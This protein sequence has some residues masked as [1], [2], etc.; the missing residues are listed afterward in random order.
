MRGY[1]RHSELKLR[2]Q[3]GNRCEKPRHITLLC[4]FIWTPFPK[5]PTI[6]QAKRNPDFFLF[7]V[8]SVRKIL[9]DHEILFETCFFLISTMA[10]AVVLSI[11]KQIQHIYFIIFGGFSTELTS[12]SFIWSIIQPL[13][14]TERHFVR[15]GTIL[16]FSD[17]I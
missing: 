12:K 5:E 15:F 8:C 1:E 3:F 9:H 17:L 4:H 6:L 14:T 13:H 7:T 2:K 10:L 16:L 11:Y